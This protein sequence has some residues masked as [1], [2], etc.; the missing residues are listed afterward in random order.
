M[1]WTNL[2]DRE[3][4]QRISILITPCLFTTDQ[5]EYFAAKIGPQYLKTSELIQYRNLAQIYLKYSF[6]ILL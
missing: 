4:T 5:A 3:L 1:I 2:N 6:T